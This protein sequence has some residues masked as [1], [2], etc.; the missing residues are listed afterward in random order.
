MNWASVKD[1]LFRALVDQYDFSGA[2]A[3][4]IIDFAGYACRH[5]ATYASAID[6]VHDLCKVMKDCPK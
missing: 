5:N 1:L 3:F 4:F 6:Y 2:R